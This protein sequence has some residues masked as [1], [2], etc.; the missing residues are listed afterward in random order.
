MMF[1]AVLGG[2][3][4]DDHIL[5]IKYGTYLKDSHAEKALNDISKKEIKI[6]VSHSRISKSFYL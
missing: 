4:L 6:V 5:T 2:A 3:N 1:H